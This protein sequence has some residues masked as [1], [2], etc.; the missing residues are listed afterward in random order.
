MRRFGSVAV[1]VCGC[2]RVVMVLAYM[3]GVAMHRY[4]IVTIVRRAVSVSVTWRLLACVVPLIV[5]CGA[6]CLSRVVLE[7]HEYI[8]IRSTETAHAL[9][10]TASGPSS[11]YY[12]AENS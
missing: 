4:T 2:C 7:T 8:P 9:I 10:I 5:S 12:L 3:G 11:Q 6:T 1:R